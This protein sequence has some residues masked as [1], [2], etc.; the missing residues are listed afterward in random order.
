MAVE[1]PVRDYIAV[2]ELKHQ[3]CHHIDH[4]EYRAWADLFTEEGAFHRGDGEIYRGHDELLEFA[5]EVFDDE[6]EYSAHFVLNPVVD[7]DGTDATGH[8]YLYLPFVKSDGSVGWL[9]A[10]YTDEFQRSN[11]DW[12][13]ETVRITPNATRSV[14]HT[15]L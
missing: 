4:G 8:W 13:I 12:Q 9:Q 7:I 2:V 14:E 5:S 10:D 6:Y 15:L 1:L 3:Y 11:G